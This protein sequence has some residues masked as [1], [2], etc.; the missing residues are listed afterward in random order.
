MSYCCLQISFVISFSQGLVDAK[1]P[2]VSKDHMWKDN[3]TSHKVMQKGGEMA[4]DTNRVHVKRGIY[5]AKE[6]SRLFVLMRKIENCIV[7]FCQYTSFWANASTLS[8]FDLVIPMSV[9][10]FHP[11]THGFILFCLILICQ[12]STLIHIFW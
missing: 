3:V 7:N 6:T 1:N 11:G 5:S 8:Y 2:Q 9:H 10:I 12:V 4:Q